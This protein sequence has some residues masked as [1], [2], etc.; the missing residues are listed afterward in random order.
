MSRQQPG[1]SNTSSQQN[2][3]SF[4][5]NGSDD[6]ILLELIAKK[7][8]DLAPLH[9]DMIKLLATVENM[10]TTETDLKKFRD[11]IM[12]PESGLFSKIQN[13]EH[14]IQTVE[15]HMK[16]MGKGIDGLPTIS[17]MNE[18]EQSVKNL[19]KDYD[20][21]KDLLEHIGG[22]NLEE[23]SAI[24]KLR[25]NMDRIYWTLIASVVL[26]IGKLLLDVFKSAH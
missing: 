1:N 3:A 10:K 16:S 8:G 9:G 7:L 12:D 19:K 23:L 14:D 2:P 20:S 25:K 22:K 24:V 17:H 18:I 11:K 5:S 4:T 21:T 13:V 26:T 6:K 15:N